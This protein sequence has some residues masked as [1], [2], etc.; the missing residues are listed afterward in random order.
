[1]E[2]FAFVNMFIL[3]VFQWI[4]LPN[5]SCLPI[6][7]NSVQTHRNRDLTQHGLPTHGTTQ[8]NEDVSSPASSRH[9]GRQQLAKHDGAEFPKTRHSRPQSAPYPKSSS[10]QYS[11]NDPDVQSGYLNPQQLTGKKQAATQRL[12]RDSDIKF[13]PVEQKLQQQTKDSDAMNI[14]HYSSPS[15]AIQ[16]NMENLQ[17]AVKS[18]LQAQD[19]GQGQTKV[20]EV[21][22]MVGTA[23]AAL[24]SL[25]LIYGIFSCCCPKKTATD[26]VIKEENGKLTSK[27]DEE[28]KK[29][30]LADEGERPMKDTQKPSQ[31]FNP[32]DIPPGDKDLDE[33]SFKDKIKAFEGS[34]FLVTSPDKRKSQLGTDQTSNR[35]SLVT[36]E[37]PSSRLSQHSPDQPSNQRHSYTENNFENSATV[38]IRMTKQ[39]KILVS[40][41]EAEAPGVSKSSGDIV[42]KSDTQD[43]I[44]DKILDNV[45][46]NSSTSM[47]HNPDVVIADTDD[48]DEFAEIQR[49]T[50]ILKSF[51]RAKPPR[52]R[53]PAT[54]TSK[55]KIR[56]P[57][58]NAAPRKTLEKQEV[59]METETASTPSGSSITATP[60]SSDLEKS[61]PLA[62]KIKQKS[63][64]LDKSTEKS[65]GESVQTANAMS[66]SMDIS[67]FDSVMSKSVTSIGSDIVTPMKRERNG[68]YAKNKDSP[69]RERKES[70]A[71]FAK[72]N[73]KDISEKEKR[74]ESP[75]RFK[76]NSPVNKRKNRRRDNDQQQN[77]LSTDISEVKPA[78]NQNVANRLSGLPANASNNIFFLIDPTVKNKFKSVGDIADDKRK[79]GDYGAKA[80]KKEETDGAKQKVAAGKRERTYSDPNRKSAEIDSS[81]L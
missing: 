77:R 56:K 10:V 68:K 43:D 78:E 15:S 14:H 41:E 20:H 62:G 64:S 36:P 34:G 71:R 37:K 45:S 79:S 4:I 3:L 7:P 16:N 46:M 33:I 60:G 50:T 48:E 1:M 42:S 58:P 72:T 80:K 69:K 23:L 44:S 55:G 47:P 26:E 59:A 52:N 39:P 13:F 11:V 22:L 67:D 70:P 21:M 29:V 24:F 2:P 18:D 19:K 32:S 66:K 74:T 61:E 35:L 5:I 17:L 31:V 65:N 12:N 49:G 63:N 25:G 73:E 38:Q 40:E 28:G 9:A 54:R 53:S 57:R 76:K 81:H 6:Q 27:E 8:L 30:G 51:Q 75:S